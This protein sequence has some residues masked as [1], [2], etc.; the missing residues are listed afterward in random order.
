MLLVRVY[1]GTA[2]WKRA[3]RFLK[4]L[5]I[6]LPCDPAIPFLS[7]FSEELNVASQRDTC[8]PIFIAALFTTA[9]TVEATQVTINPGLDGLCGLCLYHSTLKRTEILTHATA[10]V[11]IEDIMLFEMSVISNEIPPTGGTW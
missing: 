10:W 2:L 5:K 8:T 3:W 11:N 4:T 1:S 9:K 7:I 6:E